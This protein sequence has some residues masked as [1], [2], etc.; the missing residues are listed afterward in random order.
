VCR[1]VTVGRKWLSATCCH[2]SSSDPITRCHTN[3]NEMG[4][5]WMSQYGA[6]RPCCTS[7]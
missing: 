1:S 4:N 2:S 3:G 5:C 6:Q 7:Y